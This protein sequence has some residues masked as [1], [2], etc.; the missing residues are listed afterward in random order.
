MGLSLE[1]F[2]AEHPVDRD[3]VEAAKAEMLARVRAYRLRELREAAHLTQA[4]VAEKIG[5]SQRQVSKIETGDLNNSK[6]ITVRKYM[7]AV[8][9]DLA[10]EFVSGDMRVQVA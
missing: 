9:G 3:Q 5:V 2:L 1:E 8:G 7:E 4:Q 6:L 10:V